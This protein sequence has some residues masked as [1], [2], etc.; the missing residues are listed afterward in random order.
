MDELFLK[1][2]KVAKTLID[3]E[4]NRNPLIEHMYSSLHNDINSLEEIVDQ[5]EDAI[6]KEEIDNDN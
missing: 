6:S 3:N 1:L 5:I 4:R 2:F